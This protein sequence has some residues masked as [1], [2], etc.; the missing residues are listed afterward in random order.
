MSLFNKE[1]LTAWA[2]IWQEKTVQGHAWWPQWPLQ[3]SS[4]HRGIQSD[5]TVQGHWFRAA[6][7]VLQNPTS[8]PSALLS[9]VVANNSPHPVVQRATSDLQVSLQILSGLINC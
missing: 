7:E 6:L 9:T 1:R 4:L 5:R 3:Q 8:K 2:R